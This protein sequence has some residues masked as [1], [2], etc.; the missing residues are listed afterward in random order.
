MN[1]IPSQ[2]DHQYLQDILRTCKVFNFISIVFCII[3]CEVAWL[4]STVP[5]TEY[6]GHSDF[7]HQCASYGFC[8]IHKIRE[9]KLKMSPIVIISQRESVANFNFILFLKAEI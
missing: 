9:N 7:L 8:K 3:I 2:R 1:T 6:Y 4:Q 5:N